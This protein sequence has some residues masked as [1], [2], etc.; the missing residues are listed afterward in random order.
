LLAFKCS[1]DPPPVNSGLAAD[2]FILIVQ[3]A[4]QRDV[5]QQDGH[6]FAG[7]D[8]THNTTQYENTSLFTVLVRDRWG[9][10]LF[11]KS[12]IGFG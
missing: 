5:F 7:I 3:T 10:G 2:V 12:Q 9:H 1:S 8:A 4:Y 6:S 11:F